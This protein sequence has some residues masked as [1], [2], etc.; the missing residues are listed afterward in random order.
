MLTRL[1]IH[2]VNKNDKSAN[3]DDKEDLYLGGVRA[4]DK[5]MKKGKGQEDIQISR[6]GAETIYVEPPWMAE[7]NVNGASI[8]FKVDI[9]ADV[10][11]ISEELY[12]K[13]FPDVLLESTGRG[14]RVGDSI[15]LKILEKIQ[16][17]ME[18]R[19]RVATDIIYVVKKGMQPL[20]GRPAIKILDMLKWIIDTVIAEVSNIKPEDEFSKVFQGLGCYKKCHI[21]FVL[22]RIFSST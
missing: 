13:H 12:A 20:L 9:G 22:N 3:E 8:P 1:C 17:K 4:I 15:P 6:V 14:L 2:E 5:S 16:T 7:V 18:W 21:M 10:T 19:K 11:V